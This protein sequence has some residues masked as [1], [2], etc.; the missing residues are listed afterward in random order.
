M[1]RSLPA[2]SNTLSPAETAAP[3][4]LISPAAP[5]NSESVAL[6]AASGPVSV[7]LKWLYPLFIAH[8]SVRV[9]LL[10]FPVALSRDT[11]LPL[12]TELILPISPM[13]FR[14]SAPPAFISPAFRLSILPVL[15]SRRS[16]CAL[17]LPPLLVI[18][19]PASC[20][21]FPLITLPLCRVISSGDRYSFGTMT[22]CPLMVTDSHHSMLLVSCATCPAVSDTPKVS[23]SAFCCA[24]ALS[25]RYFICARSEPV[26]LI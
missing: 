7:P 6:T 18:L 19:P 14:F 13:A 3:V 12:M 15:S 8:C 17:M 25:I 16:F 1:F 11:V 21:L 9:R 2:D 24:A 20:T 5:I 4:I 23:P 10:M 26:P 22:V